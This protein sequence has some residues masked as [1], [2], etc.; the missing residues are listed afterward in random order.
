MQTPQDNEKL[1]DWLARSAMQDRQ[2]FA[3]LYEATSPRLYAVA[4]R[5]LQRPAWA[6][7]VLQ[8]SFVSIWHNAARYRP[9][10][11][12]PMT[13]MTQIVR[14]RAIDWLRGSDNRLDALDPEVVETWVDPAAG[15]SQRLSDQQQASR[16]QDCLEHL[17]AEQRQCVVLAYQHGMSHA[18]L[19]THLTR[20]LGTVKS[21]IRRGLDHL[22]GCVSA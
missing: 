10:L 12:A 19:A 4:L 7:E 2:A 15:P 16:L 8:E 21:W 13:W 3:R 22:K 9:D 1:A 18:E 5:V 6:D 17:P 11:A 14:N 20:P